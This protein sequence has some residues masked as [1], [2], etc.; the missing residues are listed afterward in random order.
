M[1]LTWH[2]SSLAALSRA[3]NVAR[4]TPRGISQFCRARH[5]SSGSLDRNRALARTSFGPW[6]HEMTHRGSGASRNE[7][8]QNLGPA[9]PSNPPYGTRTEPQGYWEPHV[10]SNCLVH[11]YNMLQGHQCLT[12]ETL[13]SHTRA[14]MQLDDMYLHKVHLTPTD[15]CTPQG[16]F[17][18]HC[19]NHYCLTTKNRAFIGKRVVFLTPAEVIYGA[20]AEHGHQGLLLTADNSGINGHFTAIKRHANG[21]F[22]VYDSL[23]CTVAELNEAYLQPLQERPPL[24]TW[25]EALRVPSE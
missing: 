5:C 10:A 14:V 18:L 1:I 8:N 24:A 4:S 16:D 22:Y 7:H 12:P 13:Q 2:S 3:T 11:A 23:Q 21:Q 20:L 19:L 17:S 6:M 15:L 25:R 9:L